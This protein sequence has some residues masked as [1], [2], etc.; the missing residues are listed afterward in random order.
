MAKISL[1][2]N[3]GGTITVAYMDTDSTGKRIIRVAV[4]EN[5]DD[6]DRAVGTLFPPATP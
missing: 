5:R 6:L 2:F 1:R 4:A 3:E